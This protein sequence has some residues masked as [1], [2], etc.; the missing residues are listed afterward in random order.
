MNDPQA[1][2]RVGTRAVISSNAGGLPE[3]NVEGVTGFLCEPGDVEGMAKKSIY[4]LQ[5]N[6]RLNQFKDNALARAKEFD[7]SLILPVYESYYREVI[8]RTKA[9]A[10]GN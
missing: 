10:W 9:P 4:V 6:E 7:L 1:A 3:L 5:D 8:E 2:E